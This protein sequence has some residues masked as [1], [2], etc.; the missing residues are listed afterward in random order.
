VCEQTH[1]HADGLLD[2]LHTTHTGTRV[3]SRTHIRTH[4]HTHAGRQA[5]RDRQQA[6]MS[7]DEQEQSKTD[8]GTAAVLN[9]SIRITSSYGRIE[10]RG[11]K[12]T[13]SPHFKQTV[14]GKWV[15]SPSADLTL[16]SDS[17]GGLW[18]EYDRRRVDVVMTTSTF[19]S[20]LLEHNFTP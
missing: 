6:E 1:P 3:P 11:T 17:Y 15:G 8:A 14:E 19:P 13:K 10:A 18:Y 16:R 9:W 2:Y 5:G 12:T 7:R 20:D 4:T